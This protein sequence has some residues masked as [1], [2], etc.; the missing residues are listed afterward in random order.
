MNAQQTLVISREHYLAYHRL[1]AVRDGATLPGV[2]FLGGF[3]SDMTGIKANWLHDWAAIRGRAYVRFDYRGHGASSGRFEDGTIGQWADDAEIVLEKLCSGPQILVGSSMGGWIALLL[4][5][6]HPDQIAGLVGVA[7]APDFTAD[8]IEASL[9]PGQKD[10]LD[11]VG[12]FRRPSDYSPDPYTITKR[13]IE[14]GR[15]NLV[16]RSPLRCDFP[17][18]LL[19]GSSDQDVDPS[20][21][22]RLLNHIACEDAQMTL[23]KGSDHRFSGKKELELIG[24]AIDDVSSAV[25]RAK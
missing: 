7:P 14:D 25:P 11:R 8:K 22:T 17:V 3:K 18:R 5:R 20:V 21:S 15:S 19:H 1:E 16:L 6:R 24:T 23:V 10:E 13:L 12:Y 4:A 9:D 2:I